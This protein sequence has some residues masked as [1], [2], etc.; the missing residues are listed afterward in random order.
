MII[1]PHYLVWFGRRSTCLASQNYNQAPDQLSWAARSST[2]IP[3]HQP[4]G[5]AGSFADADHIW[6]QQSNGPRVA[7]ITKTTHT[8][9]GTYY[10]NIHPEKRVS[11]KY[12]Q[13]GGTGF[14]FSLSAV[15]GYFPGKP[16]LLLTNPYC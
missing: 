14:P 7:V 5:L 13:K 6:E 1:L 11:I 8:S 10:T 15:S 2:R 4:F 3:H 16:Q 9:C 12:D